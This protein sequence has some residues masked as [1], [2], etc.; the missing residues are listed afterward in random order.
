MFNSRPFSD[1]YC[2]TGLAN[3]QAAAGRVGRSGP[4][5]DPWP[6]GRCPRWTATQQQAGGGACLTTAWPGEIPGGAVAAGAEA[7]PHKLS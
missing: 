1:A 4:I 6:P 2:G 7:R 3:S 5:R